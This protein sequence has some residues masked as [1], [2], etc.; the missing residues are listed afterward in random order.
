V[1]LESD[2]AG[3]HLLAQR[4]R[5]ARVAFAE[6]SEVHRERFRRREHR[7][8][9]PRTGRAGGRIRAGR[10]AR[11]AA[12]H[13]G[14]AAHE[15]LLDLLRADPVDVRVDAARGDDHAFARD[16]FGAGAERDRDAGLDVGIA[17]FPDLPDAAFLQPDVG[18]DDA[19]VID[20]ERVGD[21]GVRDRGAVALALPHAVANHLAAAELHFL[22][23]DRVVLL[24][25]DPELGVREPHAVPGRGAEHLGI[26]LARDLRH[27]CAFS[28]PITAPVKP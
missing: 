27:G 15:R 9:V 18:L 28:C 5:Q 4:L 8:D 10:G 11:P 13:R 16:H 14:D 24:D 23:V 25:L 12:E 21:D 19:P 20:D 2:G 17:R 26:S 7:V 3:L 1:E 6:E 22:A